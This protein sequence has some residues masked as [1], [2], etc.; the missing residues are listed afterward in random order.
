[1]KCGNCDFLRVLSVHVVAYSINNVTNDFHNCPTSSYKLNV[2]FKDLQF[3][4]LF[5]TTGAVFRGHI[6]NKPIHL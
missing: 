1:M 3:C 5:S 2:I 6:L 4:I